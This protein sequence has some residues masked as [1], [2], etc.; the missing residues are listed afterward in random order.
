MLFSVVA[1]VLDYLF[2]CFLYSFNV[3]AF[4]QAFKLD[5]WIPLIFVFLS[6]YYC[7]KAELGF[8]KF[9]QA[10]LVG[11]FTAF[12]ISL[13]PSVFI[14]IHLKFLDPTY[15]TESVL[16]AVQTLKTQLKSLTDV[17]DIRMIK[18][19]AEYLSTTSVEFY[20]FD[21]LIK[22][23]LPSV[24]GTLILSILFRKSHAVES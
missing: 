16:S 11:V 5:F 8:I 4:D 15:Y 2:F 14:Y 19:S 6:L 24:L 12:V 10:M 21:E 13:I 7:K 22:L 18:E 9:G 23:F 3:K 1:G 17:E 20:V